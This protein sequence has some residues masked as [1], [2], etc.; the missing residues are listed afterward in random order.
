[1][2][3]PSEHDFV[4]FLFQLFILLCAALGLGGLFRGLLVKQRPDRRRCYLPKN[5]SGYVSRRSTAC[6]RSAWRVPPRGA[7]LLVYRVLLRLLILV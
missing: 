5:E 7:E 6:L 2:T 1:M 4:L 3:F